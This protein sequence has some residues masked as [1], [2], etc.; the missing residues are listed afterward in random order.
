MSFILVTTM[1]LPILSYANITYT[2][3]RNT[4]DDDGLRGYTYISLLFA[5]I[6]SHLKNDNYE[7]RFDPPGLVHVRVCHDLHISDA[8][9]GLSLA[10]MLVQMYPHC[11]AMEEFKDGPIN[12][13]KFSVP[14]KST[15]KYVAKRSPYDR[16]QINI[17]CDCSDAVVDT[18]KA[19]LHLP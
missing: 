18:F 6:E 19:N 10:K 13:V 14:S 9:N 3:E 5:D 8:P 17:F 4:I 2:G 7:L 15:I 11:L 1:Y 16:H 12:V